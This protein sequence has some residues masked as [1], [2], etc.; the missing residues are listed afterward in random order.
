MLVL[1][2]LLA[3]VAVAS[4]FSP[5]R[6]GSKYVIRRQMSE[7]PTSFNKDELW[8]KSRPPVPNPQLAGQKMDAA[9]GRATFRKPVFEGEVNPLNRWWEA[10]AP[11]QETIEAVLKGYNPT[12][13]K[14]IY[15]KRLLAEVQHID[16][17]L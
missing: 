7:G 13:P 4:G 2:V 5:L 6:S 14:Q 17:A 1:L 10:Y 15:A 3:V 16:I 9:W 8:N 12:Y 11:T